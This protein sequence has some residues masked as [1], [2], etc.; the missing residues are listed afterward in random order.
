MTSDFENSNQT[1][2][3]KFFE[4]A[5]RSLASS[6]LNCE[7][8][9]E[10]IIGAPLTWHLNT[11]YHSIFNT[12]LSLNSTIDANPSD[13]KP[14]LTLGVAN[15]RSNVFALH[16]DEERL[17]NERSYIAI[18]EDVYLTEQQRQSI[19]MIAQILANQVSLFKQQDSIKQMMRL[20]ELTYDAS[21]DKIFVKD[22]KF[23]LVMA[24][25]AFMNMYPEDQRDEVIGYTTLEKYR[26]DE[27]EA[28]LENDR[29][30]FEQGRS[31]VIEKLL[32][33][34]G[35]M[36]SLLTIKTRFKNDAGE[37]FILGV[38]RDITEKEKLIEALSL[39]NKDLDEFANIASHDLRAPLNA[40]RGL[41]QLVELEE[42]L[43]DEGR[44]HI[45]MAFKRLN[46]MDALLSDLL[47]YSK[48][49]REN[50]EY[51]LLA[52]EQVVDAC[53]HR[54]E[55]PDTFTLSCDQASFK[56][57]K[58]PLTMILTNLISNAIKHHDRGD[59]H[60]QVKY[61]RLQ[62]Q[63]KISIIDDGPGIELSDQKRIFERFIRLKKSRTHGTG[64]G[65]ALV[66][67]VMDYYEGEVTIE[68]NGRSGSC[69]T[70]LWPINNYS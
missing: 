43:G 58:F 23:R 39:S 32:M 2:N 26:P 68:S 3:D 15:Q 28:F 67:K 33:P 17:T 8:L 70:L 25:K 49:G 41:L 60:V 47:L 56:L 57:P 35:E 1:S 22:E 52:L 27:V 66:K 20:H 9:V 37:P 65:L 31:E 55:M 40:V 24:N 54:I 16:D 46:S 34:N 36:K 4:L 5:Y 19:Q 44:S 63:H 13:I 53:K 61:E 59:G 64:F 14:S 21:N 50:H 29:I 51:E 48:V 12:A 11:E 7:R 62:A 45:A 6:F 18:S 42:D 38:A 69:F 10:T 30:A